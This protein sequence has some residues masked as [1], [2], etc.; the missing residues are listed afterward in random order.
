MANAWKS[1]LNQ[2]G[3][4]YIMQ[5]NNP[6]KHCHFQGMFWYKLENL[7]ILRNMHY[8]KNIKV[9]EMGDGRLGYSIVI[10]ILAL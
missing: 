10:R 8:F 7:K 4:M 1:N 6:W 2:F 3:T 5:K 9:L